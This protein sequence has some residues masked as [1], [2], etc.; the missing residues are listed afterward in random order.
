MAVITETLVQGA[1]STTLATT[2]LTASDTLT[3]R[4]GAGQMLS[5]F[6]GTAGSLTV[7]LNDS[8]VPTIQVEGVGP[9]TNAGVS[10]TVAAGARAAILLDNSR[11]RWD[12]VIQVTGGTGITATLTALN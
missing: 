10:A 4:P 1:G 3:Y 9:V 11:R 7:V 6:N 2:T 5:L 12:G 8:G